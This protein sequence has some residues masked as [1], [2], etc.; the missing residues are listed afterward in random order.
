MRPT[1]EL[2]LLTGFL[3]S[4][5]GTRVYS[6]KLNFSFNHVPLIQALD[7][8]KRR[9]SCGFSY[10]PNDIRSYYVTVRIVNA[11]VEEAVQQCIKGLPLIARLD[12]TQHNHYHY[13]LLP[14]TSLP[15]KENTV[16]KSLQVVTVIRTYHDGYRS[17][18]ADTAPPGSWHQVEG[19]DVNNMASIDP[20]APLQAQAS[21]VLRGAGA[22]NPLRMSVRGV[23]T[24]F[25]S[26]EPLVILDNFP[27][28]GD[29]R[30]I[31][32]NDIENITVLKDPVASTIWGARAGNG[33]VILTSR[34]GST[35]AKG[36]RLSLVANMV[37]TKRPDLS[38][39]PLISPGDD[40][41]LQ[42]LLFN[43]GFYD[44]ALNDLSRPAVPPAVEV[45]AR[46]RN[47][48][49]T[50]TQ[51][52]ASL[53]EFRKHDMIKDLG[54][55]FYQGSIRQQYHL[56]MSDG[57]PAR[58]Y[59]ISMGYDRD[60]TYLV[61]NR[62]ERYTLQSSLNQSLFSDKAQLNTLF[63]YT[64]IRTQDNNP[65]SLPV[66]YTYAGLIGSHGEP[67]AV[68]YQY[69]SGYTDTAGG[70]HLRDWAYRPL[71][72]LRLANNNTRI[73][74]YYGQ[75]ALQYYVTR[76]LT[77]EGLYR[78]MKGT[79]GVGQRYDQNSFYM[80]DLSNRF[81][82][83]GTPGLTYIPAGDALDTLTIVTTAQNLR[84]Q[85]N[86]AHPDTSRKGVGFNINAGADR[87]GQ[88]VHSQTLRLYGY[89]P[90][91]GAGS[92]A[93]PE[94][95]YPDYITGALRN[96]PTNQS[97]L[98]TYVTYV[99]F[100]ANMRVTWKD[101]LTLYGIVKKD[102]TNIVGVN[103]NDKWAPFWA[104]GIGYDAGRPPADTNDLPAILK[105][106]AGYGCNGNVGNRFG[107]LSIQ[108][109]D[110]NDYGVPQSAIANPPD[111]ALSWEKT[112][113][114]NTALDF[115]LARDR[116]SPQGRIQGSLEVYV[117]RGVGLLGYDTLP[118]SVGRTS[119]FSNSA[120]SKGAGID[121][122]L[123]TENIRGKFRWNTTLLLSFVKDKV[124][125]YAYPAVSIADYVLN[126]VPMTGR[127]ISAVYSF[128]EATLDPLTGDPRGYKDGQ[129]SSD[130]DGIM[131]GKNNGAII[132]SGHRQPSLFGGLANVFT[133]KQWTLAAL[134]DIKAFFVFRRLSMD[135]YQYV[136]GLQPAHKD[137]L[138]SWKAPGDEKKTHIPSP[139]VFNNL[140]RNTF[141]SNA[142]S[143]ITRGDCIR[144][145]NVCLSRDLLNDQLRKHGIR[146]ITGSFTI[147][148][149]G[150]LW[151]A[152]PYKIDPEAANPGDLPPS[153]NFILGLRAEF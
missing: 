24:F 67:L 138:D 109:L 11:T 48:D 22:D 58:Q 103:T 106:R 104:M 40:I 19:N 135:Y 9:G 79:R 59:Y 5:T 47:R 13:T 116:Q 62:F 100:F 96:I 153:R 87:S 94:D 93:G 78:Y 129:P 55:S 98:N 15:Q 50:Q 21:G 146:Q 112:Y 70:G 36:V 125:K 108:P 16:P 42:E 83:P 150:I 29:L 39:W 142:Q 152:N 32:L 41:A 10:N 120:A 46:L 49:I 72:E 122:V 80:R 18:R 1:V 17:L 134:M 102:A 149:V 75:V 53:D 38:Y 148:Q 113:M 20:L 130:Y 136:A 101:K 33:V 64:D 60:P 105:M 110:Y 137:Y 119:L 51:A 124:T 89:N 84:A 147:N 97:F 85:V 69:P 68:N 95:E 4:F 57:T 144:L 34:K 131:N 111:P 7:T 61:A 81:T 74:D 25:A 115:G 151:R 118:P 133:W 143:T 126:N 14:D 82:Q 121:L 114:L 99:S 132:Y 90:D 139:P 54:R 30:D 92:L 73:I 123:N 71:Q 65:G 141:Y 26:Q 45:L 128:R 56:S 37:V 86:Y 44:D 52:D 63:H 107:Y 43:R 12:D 117:K 77:V 6:Q 2:L 88:T 145:R 127:P 3:I 91:L 35:T 23:N 140:N 8:V 66:N 28:A 27:Y 76:G 31:N